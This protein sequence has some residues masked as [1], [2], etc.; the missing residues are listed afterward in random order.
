VETRTEEAVQ[1]AARILDVRKERFGLK[2]EWGFAVLGQPPRDLLNVQK[3][4][5]NL[6]RPLH[7]DRAGDLAEVAAAVELLREAK[8]LCERALRQQNRPDRPTRL[9]FAH[10][11]TAPGRR[12]FKV[13]WKAPEN[14]ANAPVHRYV[15]A[16]LDPSYGKALAV[17][18][19]EPDY[20]QEFKRY[21]A[22]DDPELCSYIISEEDLR[23]MPNLFKADSITV[24][25]A[26]GNNE[27]QSEWSILT[28]RVHNG[29]G[30][31]KSSTNKENQASN[32]RESTTQGGC[33]FDHYIAKRKGRE[34]ESWLLYQQKQDIQRWLKKRFQKTSGSKEAMIERLLSYKENNLGM[35]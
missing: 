25:V 12:R 17:G 30:R 2:L 1:A 11:C 9:S 15:V 14:R 24:Q 21:L 10:L 4:Y 28:V 35:A 29:T 16:V 22:H 5:R 26:S 13:M 23:K 3:S 33:D 19:L 27:G 20:S 8:D 34:L 6:M 32:R 7:P 18:T 31:S